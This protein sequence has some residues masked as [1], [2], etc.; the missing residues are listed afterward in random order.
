MENITD[1]PTTEI[2]VDGITAVFRLYF[3]RNSIRNEVIM[4]H[5]YAIK[6]ESF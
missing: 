3:V 4:L 5:K 1:E 6:R 2:T